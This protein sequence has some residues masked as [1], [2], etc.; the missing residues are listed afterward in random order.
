MAGEEGER[1]LALADA[2]ALGD[3]RQP[4][5]ARTPRRERRG[6]EGSIAH[7]SDVVRFA[8]RR[9]GMLDAA[10]RQV[11][12]HLVLGDAARAT[13]IAAWSS[14]SSKLLTP[15]DRIFPCSTRRSN[16]PKV[17]PSACCPGQCS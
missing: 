9:H 2:A 3:L 6:A 17:S 16:A 15:Y 14:S 8:Q 11:V 12:E 1:Q 4:L 13:S 10:L 7:H 5:P